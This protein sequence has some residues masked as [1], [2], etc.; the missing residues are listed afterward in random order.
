MLRKLAPVSRITI[1]FF[2]PSP[3]PPA[4]N[5]RTA[6]RT[7]P[8]SKTGPHSGQYFRVHQITTFYDAWKQFHIFINLH[9]Q[10]PCFRRVPPC[11]EV[12]SVAEKL[13]LNFLFKPLYLK[14][15]R[16]DKKAFYSIDKNCKIKFI[17]CSFFLFFISFR[18]QETKVWK[19]REQYLCHWW[20]KW[21]KI[22]FPP[23]GERLCTDRSPK[24]K[25]R[26][27]V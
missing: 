22:Y 15:E 2:S 11:Y 25:P 9:L 12:Q 13:L 4:R 8:W 23:T 6:M 24:D 5:K 3:P 27:L 26:V 19:T 16:Y 21:L 14:T 1:P 10:R 17:S 18:F 20:Y 7:L